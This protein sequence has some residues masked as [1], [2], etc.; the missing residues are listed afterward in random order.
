MFSKLLKLRNKK[1]FTLVELMVVAAII[2][3]LAAVAIPAY[4]NYKQ[5]SKVEVAR[6]SFLAVVDSIN[7]ND[8]MDGVV[9]DVVDSNGNV[10]G[11]VQNVVDKLDV[12]VDS[13]KMD[14]PLANYCYFNG[15]RFALKDGISDELWLALYD[16]GDSYTL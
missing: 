8:V 4:I 1:G 15:E 5:E 7:A 6:A 16:N 9:V 2:A 12:T 3:I 14:A 13:I 10:T 11:T